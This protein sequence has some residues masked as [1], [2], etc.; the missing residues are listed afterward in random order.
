MKALQRIPM[1]LQI[2]KMTKVG[3]TVNKVRKILKD[4]LRIR[5]L[6]KDIIASWKEIAN[7]AAE[8]SK[9][10]ILEEVSPLCIDLESMFI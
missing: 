1:T 8:E 10:V 6:S 7:S 9:S 5:D 2:L 3:V 4:D